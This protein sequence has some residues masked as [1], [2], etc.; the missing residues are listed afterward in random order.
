MASES[1]SSFVFAFKS[2]IRGFHV[3]KAIWKPEI[4]Q[5]LDCVHEK[6][7]TED[8]H[9]VAVIH[10]GEVVGHVPRENS[11]VCRFFLQRGGNLTVSVT[12]HKFNAGTGL[13]IP[14]L[15][16]FKSNSKTDIEALPSLL[17]DC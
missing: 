8:R 3:Y 5:I 10:K 2:T 9:A 4:G 6:D 12:G 16:T 13:E 1:E 14:G 17:K 15:Y 7:N 11:K